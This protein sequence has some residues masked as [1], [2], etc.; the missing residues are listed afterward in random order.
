MFR[1]RLL[2]GLLAAPVIIRTPGLLMPILDPGRARASDNVDNRWVD[3]PGRTYRVDWSDGSSS[4]FFINSGTASFR[5][6]LP[7]GYVGLD[8]MLGYEEII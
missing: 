7:H 4:E 8:D 3:V 2:K 5:L 6:P 1:R